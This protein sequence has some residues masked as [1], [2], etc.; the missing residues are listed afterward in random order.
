M[1]LYEAENIKV[2]EGLEGVRRVPSMYIGNTDVEG[3]HH[4]VFELV[5]NSLDEAAEG[6]C[7]RIVVTIHRDGSITCEDNGRGIPVSVHPEEGI[8]ALEVVLTRLHAGG[9]FEKGTYRYSSGLHGVGL[10]V[11]NALSEFLDVE[12]RR[13]GKVHAQRYERG[14]RVTELRVVG[15]TDHTGTKVRFRPDREIFRTVEFSFDLISQRMREIAFLNPGVRISV[16]DERKGRRHE[17]ESTEGVVGLLRYVSE[18]REPLCEPI[19][20]RRERP[21]VDF[22]EVAVQY[23]DGYSE[24]ILSFVNN[25]NTKEGG[26]HVAGFRSALTRCVNAFIQRQLQRRETVAGDDVKEGLTAVL[27]LRLASPQFE[28][29]TKTK[30]GNAE[31]KGV[32]DS[33]VFEALSEYFEMHPATGRAVALKALEAKKAKE[34]AKRARE[35]TRKTAAESL[36]LPGKLAD[37]QERDPERCELYIVEG[38]SAGGSAK[39]GRDRRTQAIL[40]LRGK[41]LNVEKSTEEK[42]FSNQ[43]LRSISQAL[44]AN[45]GDLEHIRYKKV[46]IM[47]DA[48]V[49][50]SHIRTLLLTFFY[51]KM[52]GLIERG[53]LHIAEPPLYRVKADGR[54]EYL[55]DEEEF[56]AM[57]IRRG[58]QALGFERAGATLD[59]AAVLGALSK[60]QEVERYL[61]E[62]GRMGVPKGV[63]LA[64]LR[65]QTAEGAFENEERLEATARALGEAGFRTVCLLDEEHNLFFLRVESP[66]GT[67]R[68][69]EEF[70]SNTGY[71]QV[72]ADFLSLEQFFSQ[73]VTVID[74][75]E[76]YSVRDAS[77]LR[78]LVE[79]KGRQGISVQRYKGLGEMN[80]EQLWE[81]TMNP[82]TRRLTRVTIEDALQAERIFSILMG[83]NVERRRSFIIENAPNV[84]NLDI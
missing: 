69:D 15:R 66:W 27:N 65:S 5:D 59:R 52:R 24:T 44:N 3:L 29:Q 62:M 2:L 50:G 31:V 20:F 73:G 39:Q 10:S 47:T 13:D 51:R 11:V 45:S 17:F 36:L 25:V 41:I 70:L 81:T 26:S 35:L 67:I 57:L 38:D 7:D 63:T 54:E 32:V 28:G 80:P 6:F 30:L 56:E 84:R 9:K 34:A 77:E 64:L 21:P 22:I 75:A 79:K 61:V 46:I 82:K 40:P 19:Y 1:N 43:E 8:P 49:D 14:R 55:R 68:I 33:L 76:R 58:V 4:L 71:Y 72:L 78:E 83:T 37:C 74:G 53:Y 23:N 48:D 18:G 60:W 16:V 42:I 12:V